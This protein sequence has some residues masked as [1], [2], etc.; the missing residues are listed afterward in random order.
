[1][2]Q[3]LEVFLTK[4]RESAAQISAA[5]DLIA[6]GWQTPQHAIVEL[7]CTGL[8]RTSDGR[9]VE[10]SHFAYGI[11][12]SEHHLRYVEDTS[13]ITLL[14]PLNL[15]HTNA[16]AVPGMPAGAVCVG[17]IAA[18]TELDELVWRLFDLTVFQ[19]VAVSED[20][21][22][23]PACSAWARARMDLFPVEP[24]N[25]FWRAGDPVP[26]SRIAAAGGDWGRADA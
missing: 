5:G 4:Q 21:S 24:R 11:F 18:G 20:D 22:L 17:P 3:M 19:N 26:Q 16:G 9:I 1:M 13:A 6:I 8:I 23:N 10:H 15:W 12:F 25:A 2:D 7:H 14:A